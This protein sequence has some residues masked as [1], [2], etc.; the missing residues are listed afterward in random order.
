MSREEL[1]RFTKATKLAEC[2][3]LV[4]ITAAHARLMTP[5]EWIKTAKCAGTNPPSEITQHRVIQFLESYE[6][7]AGADVE[8]IE[9]FMLPA[10]L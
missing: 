9:R 8:L 2:L 5:D 6:R 3:S 7:V 1:A 4:G 10:A